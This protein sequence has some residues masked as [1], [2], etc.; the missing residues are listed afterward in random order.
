M[1]PRLVALLCSVVSGTVLAHGANPQAYAVVARPAPFGLVNTSL[2]TFQT[3]DDGAHWDWVCQDAI[4][5]GRST[6]PLWFAT[7]TGAFLIADYG[8]LSVTRDGACSYERI[9]SFDATGV[10]DLDRSGTTLWAT[11]HASKLTSPINNRA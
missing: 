3:S 9:S 11:T 4:G 10:S 7:G 1:S 8:G 6:Q 2:G 5:P